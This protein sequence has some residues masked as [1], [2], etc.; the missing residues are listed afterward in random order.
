MGTS[1]L[2]LFLIYTYGTP[3]LVSSE[4]AHKCNLF[5]DSTLLNV[6]L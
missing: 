1:V 4:V 2:M 6:K 3:A 5:A